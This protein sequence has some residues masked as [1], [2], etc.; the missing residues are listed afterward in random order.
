[1]NRL[2]YKTLVTFNKKICNNFPN[3]GEFG[4]ANE[5]NLKSALSVF[6]SY[7][8]TEEQIAAALFR[9]LIIAH[10]FVNANKRIAFCAVEVCKPTKIGAEDLEKL[11]IEVAKDGKIDIDELATIMYGE[12]RT[13]I[14]DY[15][16]EID[17]AI[18]K[19]D[20]LNQKLFDDE[21]LKPEVKDKLLEIVDKF[22][23]NLA[24]DD[25]K[26]DVKDVVMIGS[27]ASYNYTADSDIDLHIIADLSVY[28]NQEELAEKLYMAYKALFNDKYDPTIYDIPV[29]VY[30][31]P[32][33]GE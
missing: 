9:S 26:L 20:E 31:E 30:V 14:K 24:K 8:D 18:E 6:D 10:G 7:Y 15:N 27:S 4:V 22:K 2:T 5:D 21:E 19:H 13:P 28:P 25:V 1:M 33:K 23:E 12:D 11:A 29:E 32:Y 17:E 3:Q 16:F